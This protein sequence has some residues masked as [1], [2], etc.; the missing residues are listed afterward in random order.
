MKLY[1]SQR[2]TAAQ[3][4]SSCFSFQV[5]LHTNGIIYFPQFEGMF[6]LHVFSWNGLPLLVV[7]HSNLVPVSPP[8]HFSEKPQ[9]G[10]GPISECREPILASWSAISLP[11]IT[12]CLG[13]HTPSEL[14]SVQLVIMGLMAI[15]DQLRM[16]F[17]GVKCFNYILTV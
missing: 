7:F 8:C 15:P 12:L 4:I 3:N 5:I 9:I 14:Y 6:P 10:S 11:S 16:Y 17:I 1:I 13:I 2:L